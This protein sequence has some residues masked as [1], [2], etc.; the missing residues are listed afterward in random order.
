MDERRHNE[1]CHRP[2]LVRFNTST[3]A[4]VYEAQCKLEPALDRDPADVVVGVVV[5]SPL[6]VSTLVNPI[7]C[8]ECIWS[9]ERLLPGIY[10]KWRKQ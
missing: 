5:Q 4:T 10:V 7:T 1:L 2:V 8:L 3:N 9:N 6:E